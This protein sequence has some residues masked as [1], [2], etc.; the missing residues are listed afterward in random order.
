M[1]YLE[2]AVY[3]VITQLLVCAF[4]NLRS[5]SQANKILGVFL[6]LI[7]DNIRKS[8]IPL[9]IDNLYF[10]MIVF[11]IHTDLLYGPLM[12]FYLKS[13]KE[14]VS[15]RQIFRHVLFFFVYT[16]SLLAFVFIMRFGLDIIPKSNYIN[17][18]VTETRIFVFLFYSY[19]CIRLIHQ[20][21]WSLIKYAARYNR[22]LMIFGSYCFIYYLNIFLIKY[23]TEWVISAMPYYSYASYGSFLALTIFLVVYGTT[24]VNTLKSFFLNSQVHHPSER[25]TAFTQIEQQLETIFEVDKLHLNDEISL[26][27]MAERLKVRKSE[28]SDYIRQVV[29][30]SFYDYIN[31]WRIREFKTKLNDPRYHHLDMLGVAFES[32]FQSKAT[33]NRAFKKHEKITPR[34][35]KL[36]MAS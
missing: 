15:F 31:E 6:L 30:S 21:N 2:G 23:A 13:K 17:L 27:M 3:L 29:K 16:I 20:Q 9:Y 22:F 1:A 32:G 8:F 7:V 36:R 33:F 10:N 26:S 25:E 34:E 19:L 24:E 11:N 28:L 18:M 14:W 35:Y 4:L 5:K 12:F